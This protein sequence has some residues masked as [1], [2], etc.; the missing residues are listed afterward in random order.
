M[1]TAPLP[2]T[3]TCAFHMGACLQY[4]QAACF[5]WYQ[6][7]NKKQHAL[8]LLGGSYIV[9]I[10]NKPSNSSN[11]P[12]TDMNLGSVRRRVS[13]GLATSCTG[14]NRGRVW[15]WLLD[16]LDWSRRTQAL[17]RWP[18][19]LAIFTC[20]TYDQIQVLATYFYK[21]IDGLAE[22]SDYPG[23][24]VVIKSNFGRMHLF[25]RYLILSCYII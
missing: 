9:E 8:V 24:F 12:G 13:S 14:A 2:G 22:V 25:A 4:F 3:S 21:D 17:T 23:G 19:V 10:L 16:P 1:A 7:S 11:C 6:G 18:E 5:K 15:C 20:H